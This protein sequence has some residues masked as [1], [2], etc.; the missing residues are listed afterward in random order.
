MHHNIAW[1]IPLI[2]DQQD[3]YPSLM[4]DQ[5]VTN[6]YS[7]PSDQP[8]QQLWW[9]N[10]QGGM[11][12]YDDWEIGYPE[13]LI[14]LLQKVCF[15]WDINYRKYF[16]IF[17]KSIPTIER[18]L[19]YQNLRRKQR[20]MMALQLLPHLMNLNKWVSISCI[21]GFFIQMSFHLQY[22]PCAANLMCTIVLKS[23]LIKSGIPWRS[24]WSGWMVNQNKGS[25]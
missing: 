21:R 12:S 14:R 9:L 4:T 11:L 23:T 22:M 2:I 6:H 1:C 3:Q 5:Q 13:V 24:W 7:A 8:P 15:G 19:V 16:N 10:I 17:L 25:M 18:E 20:Q